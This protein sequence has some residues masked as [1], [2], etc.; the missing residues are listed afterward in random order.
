VLDID[1]TDFTVTKGFLAQAKKIEPAE[2]VPPKELSS[3]VSQCEKMLQ[4]TPDAFLFLYSISGVSVVPAIS[5]VSGTFSNPHEFY[6]RSLSR[7]YEEHFEC[8][9]GDRAISAPNP[10]MLETLRERFRAR[11]LSY[12]SAHSVE[13]LIQ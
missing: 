6:A 5:V 3:M 11:K 12:L 8:F 9:I 1:L 13:P 2:Y 10:Q 7:F 4:Y